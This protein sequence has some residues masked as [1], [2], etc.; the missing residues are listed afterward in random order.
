M[1]ISN[2]IRTAGPFIGNGI[3][4][5][6]PFTFKVFKKEEVLAV[7]T[8]VSTGVASPLVL[9][10]GYSVVL[11]ADQNANPGGTAT[12]A[13]PL[14]I[15]QTLV[16]TSDLAYLQPLDITNGGGFYPSVLNAALDRLTI[17]CQQLSS[18][19]RRSIKFPLSDSGMNTEL[20]SAVARANKLL[21]FN[22]AGAPIIV[23][24]A[25]GS[26]A[27]LALDL[28]SSSGAGFIGWL[29]NA[30]GAV[31]TTL[32]R[33]L[34]WQTPSVLDFMTDAERTDVMAGTCLLDVSAAVQ[35]A[36][37]HCLLT[38]QNLT[39]EGVCRID[40]PVNIDRATDGTI[41]E[42][43]IIGRNSNAGFWTS[44]PICIFS[45]TLLG[46]GTREDFPGSEFTVFESVRFEASA[47]TLDCFAVNGEKFL[48]MRFDHCYFRK[49]RLAFTNN[50]FQ[51]WYLNGCNVRR[52]RG[53]FM[54][55]AIAGPS[56]LDLD[57]FGFDLHFTDN[58]IEEGDAAGCAFLKLAGQFN[59]G[60]LKG[61]LFEGCTGPFVEVGGGG[62]VEVS[63]NYFEAVSLP[64]FR[65]GSMFN[66]NF[67]GNR[68]GT[69]TNPAYWP[70]DCQTSYTVVGN[71]NFSEGNLYK[72]TSMQNTKALNDA[73][74]YNTAAKGLL[75]FGDVA[76]DGLIC[77][78]PQQAQQIDKIISRTLFMGLN[79]FSLGNVTQNVASMRADGVSGS[80]PKSAFNWYTVPGARAVCRLDVKV[81]DSALGEMVDAAFSISAKGTTSY[82][83]TGDYVNI[84]TSGE[85]T[86]P[87]VQ[88]LATTSN[89]NS[90]AATFLQCSGGGVTRLLVYGNGGI[91]NYQANNTNLSDVRTKKEITPLISYW[92]KWKALEFVTFRYIDQDDPRPNIGLI[93]QQ[94]ESV[95]P[96]FVSTDDQFGSDDGDNL[97]AIFTTDLYHAQGAVLK[98][99]MARIEAL[100][101]IIL[102]LKGNAS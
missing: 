49:I 18:L 94:V 51:S 11:N 58:I 38:N 93:A 59:G 10:S 37:T 78:D 79:D 27:D 81:Q 7:Q 3:T 67:N 62:T 68:F 29:R 101:E 45:S 33:W 20:P 8:D 86:F 57:G 60:D 61:N 9:N 52:M 76:Y 47:A 32:S 55:A 42:F 73:G 69:G 96:E 1:T 21:G 92:E 53:V 26:A 4:T 48:R 43:R 39:V 15:G 2:T 23:A 40:T 89:I 98:E 34:G 75:S 13:S 71:G 83:P 25:S 16:L 85:G 28:A 88:Q 91:A 66:I 99:A 31:L 41:N 65:L 35:A 87:S 12:M 6:F 90:T 102:T 70:I 17:F 24:P 80:I 100:E 63:G 64:V 50:F 44:Q 22:S 74:F 95:A 77:D 97:K 19:A 84:V 54:E 56:F 5:V 30:T 72:V 46:Y 14:A 82:S 36:V